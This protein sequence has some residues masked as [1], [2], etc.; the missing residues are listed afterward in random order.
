MTNILPLAMRPELTDDVL[1]LKCLCGRYDID[2]NDFFFL[3][4][5][6]QL[7]NIIVPMWNYLPPSVRH[8]TIYILLCYLTYVIKLLLICYIIH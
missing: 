4:W 7:F 1:F 8:I 2:V 6:I 3:W 5:R